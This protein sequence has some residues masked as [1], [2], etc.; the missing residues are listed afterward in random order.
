MAKK[1]IDAQT[2][3]HISRQP[4]LHQ[5]AREI[6]SYGTVNHAL[7]L[8]LEEPPVEADNRSLILFDRGDEDGAGWGGWNPISA[9]FGKAT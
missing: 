1:H 3:N 7:P 4:R 2:T 9:H 8:E 6:Q 5:R